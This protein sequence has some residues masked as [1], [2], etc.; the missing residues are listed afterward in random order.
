MISLCYGEPA[1]GAEG[2]SQA[3]AGTRGVN[4]SPPGPQIRQ[5]LRVFPHNLLKSR[6]LGPGTIPKGIRLCVIAVAWRQQSVGKFGFHPAA[7]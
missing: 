3:G 6:S 2:D 7:G 1:E 5:F 4:L